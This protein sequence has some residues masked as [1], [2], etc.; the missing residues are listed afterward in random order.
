MLG[1]RELAVGV[2]SADEEA[3]ETSTGE[4]GYHGW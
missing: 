4:N 1:K 2:E 3:V